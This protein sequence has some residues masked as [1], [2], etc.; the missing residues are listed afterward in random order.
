MRPDVISRVARAAEGLTRIRVFKTALLLAAVTAVAIVAAPALAAPHGAFNHNG[1]RLIA[2]Q[3]S[4][5]VIEVTKGGTIVWHFGT[6]SSV[7]GPHTVVAPNDAERVPGGLTLIAGTGAPAGTAGYPAAGAPDNRV[8]LVNQAGKIVWQYGTAGVT[9]AGRNELNAPVQ[10]TYLAGG[11][12][13]IT[14]QG[15]ARVILVNHNH[16]I[17]WQYGTTGKTGSTRN[18]LNNPNSAQ[19]L[20]NGNVL[21]ADEGNNRVLVVNHSKHVVWS[22]GKVSGGPLNAPAFASRLGNG[23]TLIA[24]GGNNRVVEVTMAKHAVWSYRT[25]TG[26][27]SVADP[28]PSQAVRLRNGDT[29]ISDEFND[30]VIE[31][32][33]AKQIVWTYGQIGVAGSGAGQLNAPYGAKVIGDYTG[34]TPVK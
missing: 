2:D 32:T 23:D 14:D 10:A 9:G 8:I 7:A 5:R 25:N 6:G 21:I 28:A 27:G 26:A 12:I 4:N 15:D 30:R 18:H 22:Y 29:L 16:R 24:D 19:M 11:D 13:L 33:R 20:A 17:L 3:F 1:D 31:V 34:L